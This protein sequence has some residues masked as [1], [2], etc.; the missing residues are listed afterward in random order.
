MV[1]LHIGANAVF[2]TG[3]ACFQVAQA[4]QFT[5]NGY[6]NLVRHFNHFAGYFQVVFERGWGFTVFHQGAVHHDRAKAQVDCALAYF[7]AGAVVLVHNQWNVGE[8]FN[9]SLNKVLD[10]RLACVL[11][12]TGAGLQ[13]N[14]GT[15][16]IGGGHHCLN[17]LQ[18]VHVKRRDAVAVFGSMVQQLAH[19]YE[20]HFKFSEK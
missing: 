13:N 18:V 6:A 14:R 11:A 10:E 15:H 17:L 8:R 2:F 1:Q 5:F 3:F 9:R 19:G 4:A 7:G 16:F 20:R 12:G